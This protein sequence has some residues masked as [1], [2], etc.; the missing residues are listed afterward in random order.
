M[1]LIPEAGILK[2]LQVQIHMEKRTIVGTA[3]QNINHV[4]VLPTDRNVPS[5]VSLIIF[6]VVVSPPRTVEK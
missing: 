2:V 5:A 1:R 4:S 6:Q 3:V